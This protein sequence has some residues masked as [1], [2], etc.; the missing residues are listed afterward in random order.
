MAASIF[1]KKAVF[2][3]GDITVTLAVDPSKLT[4]PEHYPAV[5]K[6]LN[7][8]AAEMQ[9]QLPQTFKKAKPAIAD[10]KAAP[11]HDDE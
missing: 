1:D 9:K 6:W 5:Q 3:W 11:V 2:Q 7:E 8:C 4:R 10:K